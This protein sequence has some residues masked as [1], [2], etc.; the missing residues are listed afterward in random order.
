M[1]V[2]SFQP[3]AQHRINADLSTLFLL[4]TK[5]IK[6]SNNIFLKVQEV[7]KNL[8][9]M[10]KMRPENASDQTGRF[11]IL[12]LYTYDHKWIES[13]PVAI[14]FLIGGAT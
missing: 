9:S 3:Q 1:A 6:E 2:Y 5:Y 10:F 13:W 11:T 12:A 7:E 8:D 4:Q 14:F